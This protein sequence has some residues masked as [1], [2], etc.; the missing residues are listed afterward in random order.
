MIHF[1]YYSETN[2][3][4]IEIQTEME[5]ASTGEL[6]EMFERFLLAIQRLP[7]KIKKRTKNLKKK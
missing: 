6:C 7:E 2:Q 4:T 5:D 3:E 1:S